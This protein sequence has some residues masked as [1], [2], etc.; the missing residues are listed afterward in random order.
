MLHS[1]AYLITL[2]LLSCRFIWLFVVSVIWISMLT[3]TMLLITTR[4]GCILEIPK[5][6]VAYRT[7]HRTET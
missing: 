7:A 2:N 4:V 1:H 5:A 6:S 3:Y